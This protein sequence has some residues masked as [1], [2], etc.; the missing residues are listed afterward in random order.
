MGTDSIYIERLAEIRYPIIK[1]GC[2]ILLRPKWEIIYWEDGVCK[3]LNE[4]F[5]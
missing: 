3:K 1:D 5:N 4:P 2:K